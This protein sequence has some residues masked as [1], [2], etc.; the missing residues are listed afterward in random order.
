[1]DRLEAKM[2]DDLENLEDHRRLMSSWLPH[3]QAV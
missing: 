3:L 1:M 2:V